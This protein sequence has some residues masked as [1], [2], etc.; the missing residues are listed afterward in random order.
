MIPLTFIGKV[1]AD[2]KKKIVIAHNKSNSL[3]LDLRSSLSKTI[4][5]TINI[6]GEK[7]PLNACFMHAYVRC[8]ENKQNSHSFHAVSKSVINGYNVRKAD[9]YILFK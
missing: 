9:I 5:K 7:A 3:R 8:L 6:I 4:I 2:R 1:L